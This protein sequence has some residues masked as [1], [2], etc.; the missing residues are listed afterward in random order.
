MADLVEKVGSRYLLVNLIASR[1]RQLSVDA[2]AH[3]VQLEKK[4]V[5][6]AI[7][8]V[9]TGKLKVGSPLKD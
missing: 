2:E 6:T 5:S 3:G 8:E 4:P 7:D 1:A 9:Y